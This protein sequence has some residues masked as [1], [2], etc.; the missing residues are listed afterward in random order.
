MVFRELKIAKSENKSMNAKNL[1]LINKIQ[2]VNSE[3]KDIKNKIQECYKAIFR[4]S[5]SIRMGLPEKVIERLYSRK[6]SVPN[7][8]YKSKTQL[9]PKK[10][11]TSFKKML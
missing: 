5:Q 6:T 7:N 1:K 3:S 4:R 9:Q 8:I 11:A 10:K 2:K